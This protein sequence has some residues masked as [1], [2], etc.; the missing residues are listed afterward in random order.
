MFHDRARIRVQETEHAP[1]VIGVALADLAAARDTTPFDVL[2]E[3]T[4]SEAVASDGILALRAA[5]TAVLVGMGPGLEARIPVAAIQNRE[6]TLVGPFR[7]ANAYP[8]AIALAAAGRVDLD[9]LVD[10]RF[11][12]EEADHALRATRE[13]P[14]LLKVVVDAAQRSPTERSPRG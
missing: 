4:G 1:D 2:L 5:G 7:Y 8:I 12:L 14:S 9:R 11:P 10:A 13:D 6:L 3:C